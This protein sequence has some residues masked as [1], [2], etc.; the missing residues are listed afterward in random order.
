MPTQPLSRDPLFPPPRGLCQLGQLA[1][2]RRLSQ[3]QTRDCRQSMNGWRSQ[4]AA[5]STTARSSYCSLAGAAPRIYGTRDVAGAPTLP[6]ACTSF[7]SGLLDGSRTIL[8]RRPYGSG[9]GLQSG[10][11]VE[12]CG[13]T[14]VLHRDARTTHTTHPA[15]LISS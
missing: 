2:C 5:P 4:S 8:E 1:N 3:E 14:S 11:R 10:L 13:C 12:R 7:V 15:M 9:G 6:Y